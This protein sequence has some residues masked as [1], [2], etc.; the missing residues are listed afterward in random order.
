M[1]EKK[2]FRLIEG[3]FNSPDAQFLVLSFFNDKI[4]YHNRE[5]HAMKIK[6]DERAAHVE[7]KIESL[8]LERDRFVEYLKSFTGDEILF[9]VKGSIEIGPIEDKL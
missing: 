1:E 2:T 7:A 9:D 4:M 6:H 5:L 8:Q 3:I